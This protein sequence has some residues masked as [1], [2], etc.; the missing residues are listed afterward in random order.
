MADVIDDVQAIPQHYD[1][2]MC[3]TSTS[4]SPRTQQWIDTMFESSMQETPSAFFEISDIALDGSRI[5]EIIDDSMMSGLDS[6]AYHPDAGSFHFPSC[7][8]NTLINTSVGCGP[9]SGITAADNTVPS[10]AVMLLKHYQTAVLQLLTPFRHSKTPW[11][12]LFIPHAKNCLAALTLGE[13]IDCASLCLFYGIL[14]ISAFSMAGLS[15]SSIWLDQARRY[16]QQAREFGK[17]MLKSA[18]NI[19]KRAKYKSILMALLTLVQVS[20]VTGNRDQTECYFLEAEKFIRLRGLNRK[21]SRKVRLLHHCYAFERILHESTFVES[22]NSSHRLHVREAVETSGLAIFQD[23]M[24]FRLGTWSDLDQDMKRVKGQEEG[25][26]DLHL[27]Y[28]GVWSA[29][30]Y[31]EIFGVPETWLFLISLVIRLARE[32]DTA[33]Q[34]GA[35]DDLSAKDFLG[36]AKA[37]ERCIKQMRQPRSIDHCADPAVEN[38]LDAMRNALSIYFYRKIYDLDPSLL[39]QRV[40]RVRDCLLKCNPTD[41]SAVYGSARLLWPVLIAASEA[42]NPEVQ[43]S[44]ALWLKGAAERSGLR[45]F[46]GYIEQPRADLEREGHV[47]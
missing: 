11:H 15:Q 20:M 7:S 19:P 4:F 2:L 14:A 16:K 17:S 10:D 6:S 21:K 13:S 24:S 47:F 30:L 12:V 34:A 43:A 46:G 44:F 22:I 18:Y 26:N 8:P 41:S 31:P 40:E 23:N 45:L 42:T 32:K 33:Q 29:T 25:E 36:R 35:S 3:A 28:P 9:G 27:E 38:M 37:I 1:E 39:Q 5:E